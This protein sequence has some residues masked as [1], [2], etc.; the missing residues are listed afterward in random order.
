M[1]SCQLLSGRPDGGCCI[2]WRS[3]LA[4]K[5]TPVD[6]NI[7]RICAITV[8]LPHVKLLLIN[9]YMPTDARYDRQNLSEFNDSLSEMCTL[10]ERLG[11]DHIII[12]G[13]LNTDF[14]RTQSPHTVHLLRFLSN[15]TLFESINQIDYTFESLTDGEDRDDDVLHVQLLKVAITEG[16]T[17]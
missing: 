8:D 11:V 3:S 14:S 12:G 17:I 10:G 1:D 7:K 6:C 16:A 4:C 9:V 2:L 5:I 13:D 15:E